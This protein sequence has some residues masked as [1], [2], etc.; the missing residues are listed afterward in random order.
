MGRK[1]LRLY[2]DLAWLWPL[3]ENVNA[4]QPESEL[5]ARLI[6]KH[7]QIRVRTLLDMGC[8]GGKNAFHLKR[9]FQVTGI[10]K[11]DAMLANARKLNLECD[12]HRKD[13]RNF[14]LGRQFDSVFINDAITYMKTERELRHVFDMAYKHLRPGGVMLSCPDR[15]KERFKQN[16]TTVWTSKHPGRELTFIE[17]NYDPDPK[18][19]TYESTF[20]YLIRMK[21][22]L[23][24][25]HDFHV[26]GL[27]AL[28]VWRRLLGKARFQVTEVANR[29]FGDVPVFVCQKST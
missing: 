2:N 16:E 14:S 25:E 3:W 8:G 23:R 18:D 26:C 12:F 22:K 19:Q 6:R 13:M 21:G 28:N 4:Y 27:F 7:A 24:I 5:F 15:C 20:V 9:H 10:D 1:S 17:N 11:S 29:E